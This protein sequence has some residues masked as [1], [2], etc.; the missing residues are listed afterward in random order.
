[1]TEQQ[2]LAR[3]KLAGT[4]GTKECLEVL[5][6]RRE[7]IISRLKNAS[8]TE[9][10]PHCFI[11]HYITGELQAIDDLIALGEESTKPLKKDND[12]GRRNNHTF[13]LPTR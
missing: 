11:I 4:I 2:L 3:N 1:M 8:P 13:Q 10:D 6:E 9:K 5:R 12:N 7:V